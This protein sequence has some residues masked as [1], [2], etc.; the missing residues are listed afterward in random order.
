MRRIT[1]VAALA[2]AAALTAP[3]TSLA[4]G[5]ATVGLS[6]LPDDARP[7]EE[8]VVDMTVLQHGRT[9]LEGVHPAM[10][11][12]PAGSGTATR[13]DA[14]PTGKPGVYRA[15]VVFPSAGEWT[16]SADDGFT[17]VHRMGTVSV[18]G[19]SAATAS[20]AA[21]VA[22]ASPPAGPD[23]GMSLLGALG[24]AALAGLLAAVL[25]EPVRKLL[26]S[27]AAEA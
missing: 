7:G 9:P 27:R 20:A 6:S 11:I 12:E 13:F 18:G 15:T 19:D 16:Y 21:T 2:L 10:I 1:L 26:A 25:V 14:K 4:G 17:Q 22:K 23:D 24:L 8:W 5:F 3:A